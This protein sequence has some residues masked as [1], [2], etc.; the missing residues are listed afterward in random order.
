MDKKNSIFSSNNDYFQTKFLKLIKINENFENINFEN[1]N[2]EEC[3][4]SNSSFKECT[5]IDCGF[6]DSNLSLM[7]V[8][9]SSFSNVSFKNSKTMGIDWSKLEIGILPI[10]LKFK[11]CVVDLSV[12][13]SLKVDKL[14]I[15]DCSAKEVDFR[16][17]NLTKANF[18]NSNLENSLFH[19]TKLDSANFSQA[20]NYSINFNNNEIKNSTHSIAG[21]L[22]LLNP[23]KIKIEGF[24][25]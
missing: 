4:F 24:I 5:F 2:F 10:N 9:N 13:N 22:N 20:Q 12:F 18:S 19:N 8:A 14:E 21:A 23:L 7:K 11:E 25:K 15:I 17:A 16:G 6:A 1:C 3:N